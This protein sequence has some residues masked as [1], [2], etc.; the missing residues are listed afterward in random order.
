MGV[1]SDIIDFYQLNYLWK[2]VKEEEK[3]GKL[4]KNYFSDSVIK[5]SSF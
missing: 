4:K 3:K 2:I 5:L 1:K